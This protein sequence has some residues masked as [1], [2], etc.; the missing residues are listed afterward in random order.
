MTPQEFVNK[1]ANTHLG[2]MQSAQPHFR[3]VCDLVGIEMP[4]AAD[5]APRLDQ[6]H[7]TL[8][9]AVCDAYGWPHDILNNEEEILRRLL[10]LNLARAAT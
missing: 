1:W 2:E 9:H 5:F 10:A 3:D 7:Q 4:A 8:D 6:L